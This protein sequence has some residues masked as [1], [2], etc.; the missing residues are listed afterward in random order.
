MSPP[1]YSPDLA[2]NKFFFFV[3]VKNIPRDQ[4]FSLP[5]EGIDALKNVKSVMEILFKVAKILQGLVQT[6]AKKYI[7]TIFNDKF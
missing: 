2:S 3:N 7:I 5:E 6:H 1:H 4:R